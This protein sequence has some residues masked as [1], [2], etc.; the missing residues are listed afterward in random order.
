[1]NT[2]LYRMNTRNASITSHFLLLKIFFCKVIKLLDDEF[3]DI[4]AR[5]LRFCNK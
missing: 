3:S 5:S 2:A 4:I 1:M